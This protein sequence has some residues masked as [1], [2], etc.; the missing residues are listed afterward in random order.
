MDAFALFGCG[1]RAL[2]LQFPPQARLRIDPGRLQPPLDAAQA[3]RQAHQTRQQ[4]EHQRPGQA[5]AS[6][7]RSDFAWVCRPSRS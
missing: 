5:H 2:A 6:A 1:L 7:A 4:Q 3:Q